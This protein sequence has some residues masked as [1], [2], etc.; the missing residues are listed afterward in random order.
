MEGGNGRKE[1]PKKPQKVALGD[2]DIPG[3]LM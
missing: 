3:S 1:A 2:I